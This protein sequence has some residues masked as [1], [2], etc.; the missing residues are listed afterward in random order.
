MSKEQDHNDWLESFLQEQTDKHRLYPSDQLW[1]NIQENIH[2]KKPWPA[3]TIVALAILVALTVSTLLNNHPDKQAYILHLQEQAQQQ[4][5]AASAKATG[6]SSAGKHYISRFSG[7]DLTNQTLLIIQEHNELEAILNHTA[8]AGQQAVVKV[9]D[10]A[11]IAFVQPGIAINKIKPYVAIIGEQMIQQE[12]NNPEPVKEDIQ[13][14]TAEEKDIAGD[15]RR[16]IKKSAGHDHDAD[17][18]LNEHGY[19]ENPV[20]K[21]KGTPTKFSYQFWT[22]PSTGF[23]N[24]DEGAARLLN[25]ANNTPNNGFTSAVFSSGNN[26]PSIRHRPGLGLE[27]GL[28]LLCQVKPALRVK[29]GIQFN[30]RHY[31]IEA[32]QSGYEQTDVI[33]VRDDR[34]VQK[35]PVFTRINNKAG[36]TETVIDN[37]LYQL[38]FPVGVQLDIVKGKRV[39][40]LIDA[41]IQPTLNL[42]SKLY[43]LTTDLNHY[44]DGSALIRRWNMNSTIGLNF[45]YT[46]SNQV[47]WQ[48]GPQFRYQHLPTYTNAYPIRENFKDFG[49]KMGMLIPIRH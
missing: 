34:T 6:A 36:F 3:L 10:K 29:A 16:S 28:A 38:A 20:I 7:A 46:T 9:Q 21:K 32:F 41:S 25:S 35:L 8:F 4:E 5:I 49:V 1:Q 14:A 31:L 15:F 22:S 24:L 12:V 47:S 44:F 2:G 30:L 23:R 40:L 39:G 43:T 18:F 17:D 13:E 27:L 37:K 42:N 33:L 26:Q 45:S 11:P 19:K 48:I